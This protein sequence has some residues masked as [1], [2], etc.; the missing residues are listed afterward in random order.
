MIDK[1]N[2]HYSMQNLPSIYDE[3]A[4]TALELAARTTGKVNEVVSA[5]NKLAA[6]TAKTLAGIPDVVAQDVQRH[7]ESGDFAGA[8]N[9]Y[10]GDLEKR[11]ENLLGNLKTGSTTLDAEVIDIR[12]AW[13]R[14]THSSA[15]AAVR[16]NFAAVAG[17]LDHLAVG[18]VRIPLLWEQ[19]TVNTATGENQDNTSRV[20]SPKYY[21]APANKVRFVIPENRR[22]CVVYFTH[23][24]G[25]YTV[26]GSEWA[27]PG[28]YLDIAAKCTH[29]RLLAA[30]SAGSIIN[31]TQAAGIIM[32]GEISLNKDNFL[33]NLAEKVQKTVTIVDEARMVCGS[34][35]GTTHRWFLNG[36]NSLTGEDRSVPAGVFISEI[37]VQCNGAR[38]SL[39]LEFWN[40]DG[41]TMTLVHTMPV[42]H[43]EGPVEVHPNYLTTGRTM[44]SVRVSGFPASILYA[45]GQASRYWFMVVPDVESAELRLSNASPFTGMSLGATLKYT[46]ITLA[47]GSGDTAE[48][49]LTVGPG[50]M[51]EE[52]QDALD[53]ISGET[54]AYTIMVHPRTQ[55]YKR[56]STIRRL[57]EL[58]PWTGAPVRNV[59]IIG[60]DKAHC[61]V[62]DNTGDYDTPPAEFLVNGVVKGLTFWASH[63]AQNA[64]AAKG[65]YAVH[66]DAE[67]ATTAGYKMRFEDCVFYSDTAPAVG[68]GLHQNAD[69]KF[70]G[71]EF[72]AY[73][74]P[75]FKPSDNYT[76]LVEHGGLFCHT[77]SEAGVTNQ[78][79]TVDNCRVFTSAKKALWV[80]VAGNYSLD[81]CECRVYAYNNVFYSYGASPQHAVLD[82][83]IVT[84]PSSYG[85]NVSA[86]NKGGV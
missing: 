55:P 84:D 80:S 64:D 78:K 68:I 74:N 79:L 67:P 35:L 33:V 16:D 22:V 7:I 26:T 70:Q 41:D 57:S 52:I 49:V 81:T 29:F 5:Q 8:I 51:F 61:V 45:S 6:D 19:G 20:R 62:E 24:N 54:D 25:I 11:L 38:G 85:N 65:S 56:F 4:L 21:T 75:N 44:V 58:Y 14:V 40:V 69:L 10:V 31:T 3:E 39:E 66:I 36:Y 32:E 27:T 73:G 71:C 86:L 12:T 47:G 48:N 18:K 46:S 28:C 72:L 53:A 50:L 76:N 2:D 23:D 1:L 13:D 59:S 34:T 60:L 77:S 63:T 83:G 9:V 17:Q 43:I 30:N 82:T 42:D 15:G 37:R